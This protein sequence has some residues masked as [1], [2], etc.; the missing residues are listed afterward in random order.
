M[1]APPSGHAI[2]K[3][4]IIMMENANWAT[5]T[6]SSSASFVN[7]TLVPLGAHAEA[8]YNP[9]GIHPSLP[10][11][12]WLEAGDNLGVKADGEPSQF[13]QATT[14]H[15]VDQLEKAGHTW[16]AYVEDVDGSAC[17]L[18]DSGLFVSRHVPMLYFDDVTNSNDAMAA[19]CKAH[20]V[21][22]TQLQADLKNGTVADYNFITP[23]LC[24]DAHGS[25]PLTSTACLPVIT[26]LIKLGDTFLS[27][28]VQMITASPSFA[29]DSVLFVVWDEG[30]GSSSDG[31]IGFIA[32]GA[33]VK[34]A[35]NGYSN[36]IKYDH[37]STLR[38]IETIFGLPFLRAAQN[39]TDLSDL[40]TTF[41]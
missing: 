17:P 37:S 5:W 39:A 9:A 23:N 28:S 31:P 20:V 4:F 34:S 1:A 22:Y 24:D 27:S 7:G 25:N 6:K 15:L 21:P 3:V 10:N 41:P 38:T 19:R 26:D 36:T 32:I 30:D 13:H 18:T 35:A 29:M 12:I 33:M 16:K 40:F 14:D 8:Y 2:K 11:Y